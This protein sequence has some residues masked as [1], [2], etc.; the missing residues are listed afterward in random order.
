MLAFSPSSFEGAS[1]PG[2]PSPSRPVQEGPILTSS[3]NGNASLGSI[4]E[5]IT[6]PLKSQKAE[7]TLAQCSEYRIPP[8]PLLVGIVYMR[9]Q[10]QYTG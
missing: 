4:R 8:G 9:S 7:Q 2:R 6:H 3:R 5:R 1:S 10:P